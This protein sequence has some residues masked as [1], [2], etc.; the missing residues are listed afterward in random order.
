MSLIPLSVPF[1][2]TALEHQLTINY[3]WLE[4]TWTRHGHSYDPQINGVFLFNQ[5]QK[6]AELERNWISYKRVLWE[7][8]LSTIKQN[9]GNVFPLNHFNTDLIELEL[10][11][12][13]VRQKPNCSGVYFSSTADLEERLILANTSGKQ[14]F[15]F[16]S[17]GQ[18]YSGEDEAKTAFTEICDAIAFPFEE[19]LKQNPNIL[20]NFTQNRKKQLYIKEGSFQNYPQEIL[21]YPELL[22]TEI[23]IEYADINSPNLF[24][25]EEKIKEKNILSNTTASYH[26]YLSRELAQTKLAATRGALCLALSAI[27]KNRGEKAPLTG[28]APEKYPLA[29]L[30]IDAFQRGFPSEI[31]EYTRFAEQYNSSFSGLTSNNIIAIIQESQTI[32]K[33]NLHNVLYR[34]L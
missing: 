20:L 5:W 27:A 19:H 29:L 17:S 1:S 14:I 21:C 15:G 26:I 28:A 31:M 32:L 22:G 25:I 4:Y 9:S 10:D 24:K 3:I 16:K 34:K 2:T 6:A 33:N 12:N 30:Q 13:G 7:S 11:H 8:L 23:S 18:F